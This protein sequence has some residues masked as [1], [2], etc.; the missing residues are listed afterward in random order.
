M[1]LVVKDPVVNTRDFS[2]RL[3]GF[4]DVYNNLELTK[5]QSARMKKFLKA[6][7]AKVNRLA[8]EIVPIDTH[9]LQLSHRLEGPFEKGSKAG[10]ITVEVRAGGMMSKGKMVN[11]AT[12]VH[13]T[14]KPW[15]QMAL[16]MITPGYDKRLANAVKIAKG[17]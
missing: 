11:Y 16:S 9:A 1:P 5:D 13:M 14:N 4:S 12:K 2:M 7:A 8:M 15:L 3:E 17:R 10:D 6:E